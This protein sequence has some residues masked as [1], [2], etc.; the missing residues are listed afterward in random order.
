MSLGK[1]VER[2]YTQE[3]LLLAME[4]LRDRRLLSDELKSPFV[5]VG[6]EQFAIRFPVPIG[7]WRRSS[8]PSAPP[9][10]FGF[11]ETLRSATSRGK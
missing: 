2:V 9:I 8:Q 6:Y 10:D 3:W 1:R 4:A 5:P 7:R 11:C